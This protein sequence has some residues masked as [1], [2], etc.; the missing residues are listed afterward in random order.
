MRWAWASCVALVLWGCATTAVERHAPGTFSVRDYLKTAYDTLLV[1]ETDTEGHRVRAQLETR[2]ALEALDDA[3]SLPPRRVPYSGPPT[4]AVALELLERCEQES[5][6]S[7]L[8]R[9]H[10]R[11]AVAA[12]AAQV[13]TLPPCGRR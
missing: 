12:G 8:A 5:G 3:Q 9:T 10:S 7:V 11:R 2:A 1:A 4:L 6:Q 13:V